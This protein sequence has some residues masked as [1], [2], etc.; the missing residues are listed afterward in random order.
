MTYNS[1]A[2]EDEKVTIGKYVT[3]YY[4]S[5][6][7]LFKFYV[8]GLNRTRIMQYVIYHMASQCLAGNRK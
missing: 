6:F 5:S 2:Y 3:A 8:Q 4:Q 1:F 7:T